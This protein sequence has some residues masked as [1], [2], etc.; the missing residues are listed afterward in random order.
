[1][2]S[3]R[4]RAVAGFY[5]KERSGCDRSRTA[6][7]AQARVRRLEMLRVQQETKTV[8]E[9]LKMLPKSEQMTFLIYTVRRLDNE[10]YDTGV[11]AILPENAM[12]L[13]AK[14]RAAIAGK[15]EAL[16]E[17]RQ[18]RPWSRELAIHRAIMNIW[19]D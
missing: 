13:P 6:M 10:G 3:I 9:W 12:E 16:V 5:Q 17:Q 2:V 8:F 1:K 18:P 19:W 14:E 11:R 7:R 4:T 15:L